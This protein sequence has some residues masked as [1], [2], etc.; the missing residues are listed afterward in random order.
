MQNEKHI[1]GYSIEELKKT[2][3]W[4][5]H[6]GVEGV[7]TDNEFIPFSELTEDI[8]NGYD[9]IQKVDNA[10]YDNTD[11]P[12]AI[13][14]GQKTNSGNSQRLITCWD[15]NY[16]FEVDE[17]ERL[18]IRIGGKYYDWDNRQND[19]VDMDNESLG[20]YL[21]EELEDYITIRKRREEHYDSMSD[22]A[23]EYID[24]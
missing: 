19:I 3:S 9:T 18:Y 1:S 16:I 12:L 22:K 13:S 4:Y 20:Y 7:L 17:Y 5:I 14:R 24:I 21:V 8:M 10:Y 23:K 15:Y 6:D 11:E 2:K